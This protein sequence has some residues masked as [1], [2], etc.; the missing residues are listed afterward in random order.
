MKGAVPSIKTA[1]VPLLS[2]EQQHELPRIQTELMLL[3]SSSPL[4]ELAPHT[5]GG[6]DLAEGKKYPKDSAAGS[7]KDRGTLRLL[8]E[9]RCLADVE[10][11]EEGTLGVKEYWE[12]WETAV[13]SGHQQPRTLGEKALSACAGLDWDTE[14]KD[15]EI[16]HLPGCG[17]CG[18]CMCTLRWGKRR[19]N[20]L[21]I[22]P[23]SD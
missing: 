11:P 9:A 7:I 15:K 14:G 12:L 23:D 3:C 19:L 2:Q 1:V 4:P 17:Q 22:T 10:A 8:G 16:V 6:W 20:D 5:A 13:S 21:V 18:V